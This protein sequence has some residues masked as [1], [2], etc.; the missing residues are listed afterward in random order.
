M[1]STNFPVGKRDAFD[2]VPIS[3]M[4]HYLLIVSWE[5]YTKKNKVNVN[6]PGMLAAGFDLLVSEAIE[7]IMN[8]PEVCKI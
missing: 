1:T 8:K 2:F 6:I 5:L 4:I 3:E 7:P